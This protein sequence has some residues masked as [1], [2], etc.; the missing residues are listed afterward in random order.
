MHLAIEQ[1]NFEAARAI[2]AHTEGAT[3]ARRAILLKA[4]LI[5]GNWHTPLTLLLEPSAGDE[6]YASMVNE[7]IGWDKTTVHFKCDNHYTPLLWALD[8]VRLNVPGSSECVVRLSS[9]R[10]LVSLALSVFMAVGH[11]SVIPTILFSYR[12]RYAIWGAVVFLICGRLLVDVF[13]V[14]LGVVAG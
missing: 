13:T 7:L 11:V 5:R 3:A 12:T 4:C 14:D 1:R 8:S 2:F 10:P 6:A 9:V